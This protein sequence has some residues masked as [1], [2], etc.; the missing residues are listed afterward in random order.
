MAQAGWGRFRQ[1]QVDRLNLATGPDRERATVAFGLHLFTF[2]GSPVVVLQRAANAQY[3]SPA[4]LEVLAPT[5]RG[6]RRAA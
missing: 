1:G 4:R 2:D 5:T 3:D 6:R